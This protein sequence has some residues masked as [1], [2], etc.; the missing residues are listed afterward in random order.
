VVGEGND[1]YLIHLSRRKEDDPEW[2]GIKETLDC[3]VKKNCITYQDRGSGTMQLLCDVVTNV[4]QSLKN[5]ERLRSGS[6]II[7]GSRALIVETI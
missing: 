3:S 5:C 7:V 1:S 2:H 4:S 6:Q